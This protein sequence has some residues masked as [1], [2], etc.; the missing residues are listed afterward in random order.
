MHETKVGAL[1]SRYAYSRDWARAAW[2]DPLIDGSRPFYLYLYMCIENR[3]TFIRVFGM[4]T[5]Q[6]CPQLFNSPG[7][8]FLHEG[9]GC[10]PVAQ[11]TVA[12]DANKFHHNPHRP[13]LPVVAYQVPPSSALVVD[14][15][16]ETGF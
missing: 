2:V 6:L 4:A 15:L 14:C 5:A 1:Q 10:L 3:W 11:V 7:D 8:D 12:S 9:V 16:V 13:D